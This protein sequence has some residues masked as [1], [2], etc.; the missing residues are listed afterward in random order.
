[1][2][3]SDSDQTG[4]DIFCD[5]L[6]TRASGMTPAVRSL[7]VAELDQRDRRLGIAFEVPRLGDQGRH[8]IVSAL[9]RI[10]SGDRRALSLRLTG[11]TG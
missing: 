11:N 9:L 7:K 4:V 8:D 1:M 3:V 10:A 2:P 5:D 6:A